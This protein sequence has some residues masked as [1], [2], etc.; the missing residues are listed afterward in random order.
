MILSTGSI[1]FD[2]HL[3][4]AEFEATLNLNVYKG[5]TKYSD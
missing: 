3:L 4:S 1:N 5:D 2:Q